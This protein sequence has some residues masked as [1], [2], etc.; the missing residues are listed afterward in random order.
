MA[1]GQR[2]AEM[3]SD[4]KSLETAL[5]ESDFSED[6]LYIILPEDIQ[7]AADRLRKTFS[8]RRGDRHGFGSI[9]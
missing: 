2:I 8:A 7:M 6:N 1:L 4:I 3:Y 9:Q 5:D